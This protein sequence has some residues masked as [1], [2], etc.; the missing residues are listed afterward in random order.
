M[1]CRLSARSFFIIL[2]R[3]RHVTASGGTNDDRGGE[4]D[5]DQTA[6]IHLK[7]PWWLI[8]RRYECSVLGAYAYSQRALT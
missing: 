8:G 7:A 2:G 4:D 6:G 3:A 5:L 1:R